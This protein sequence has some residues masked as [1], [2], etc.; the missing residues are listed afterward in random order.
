RVVESTGAPSRAPGTVHLVQETEH[1]EQLRELRD[2]AA[3]VGG[4]LEPGR[5]YALAVLL[6]DGELFQRNVEFAPVD[7][8][9]TV[10]FVRG[11]GQRGLRVRL[12]MFGD[13]SRFAHAFLES[14][15]GVLHDCESSADGINFDDPRP[16]VMFAAGAAV[17]HALPA[18]ARRLWMLASDNRVAAVP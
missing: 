18:D 2:G 4:G 10:Q 11:E 1:M 13:A 9:C 16:K 15:A 3:R 14:G 6:D 7:G 5:T 8:L 17:V 12:P